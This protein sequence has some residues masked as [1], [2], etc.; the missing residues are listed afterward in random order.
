M[1]VGA[2]GGGALIAE[3]WWRSAARFDFAALVLMGTLPLA[4]LGWAAGTPLLLGPVAW[5]AAFRLARRARTVDTAQHAPIRQLL[6][7][8]PARRCQVPQA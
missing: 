7:S 3:A 5:V 8:R 6:E 2:L 1:I 4:I